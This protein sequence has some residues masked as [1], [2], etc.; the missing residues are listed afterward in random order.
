VS[1]LVEERVAKARARAPEIIS[2]YDG[3]PPTRE[4]NG[5]AAA[6]SPQTANIVSAIA[7]GWTVS[8]LALHLRTHGIEFSAQTIAKEIDRII[9]DA[10]R[11][12]IA[13]GAKPEVAARKI[14]GVDLTI[15]SDA[16]KA[17]VTR[18][19]ARLTPLSRLSKRS[20]NN[21]A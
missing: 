10:L 16:V 4:S 15:A 13:E 20:T 21:N 1:A 11:R 8:N 14:L 19:L 5:I 3:P 9:D 12:A 7:R 17:R 2:T 6:L 18:R